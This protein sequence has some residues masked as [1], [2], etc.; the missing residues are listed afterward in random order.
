M[1]VA[2]REWDFRSTSRFTPEM[3]RSIR[4]MLEHFSHL[5]QV[6]LGSRVRGSA[7]VSSIDLMTLDFDAY[8]GN[9]SESVR[10]IVQLIDD[11]FDGPVVMLVNGSLLG[12][13]LTRELGGFQMRPLDRTPTVTELKVLEFPIRS[14]VKALSDTFKVM[15]PDAQFAV[16]D[17]DPSGQLTGF[18]A[19][20]E[21]VLVIHFELDVFRTR[22]DFDLLLPFASVQRALS[23]MVHGSSQSGEGETGPVRLV[24]ALGLRAISVEVVLGRTEFTLRRIRNLSTGDVVALPVRVGEP[25]WAYAHGRPVLYGTRLGTVGDSVALLVDGRLEGGVET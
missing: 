3:V 7:E 18:V 8:L 12:V 24:P 21:T 15:L 6:H 5:L 11:V 2:A 23:V 4:R 10:L 13:L 25:L 1:T 17:M 16:G 9:M 19:P 14:L 22:A 20:T